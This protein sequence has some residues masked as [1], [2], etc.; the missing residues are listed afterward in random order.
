MTHRHYTHAKVMGERNSG[1][2]FVEALVAAN[3]RVEMLPN[4]MPFTARDEEMI[5]RIPITEAGREAIFHRAT[6]LNHFHEFARHAGW[7][8]ACLT[9]RHFK[10]VHN[11]HHTLFICVLRHPALWLKS[12]L[13][14]PF[15]TFYAENRAQSVRELFDTPW[16]TRPR[17]EITALVL[18]TPA[19]LW[20]HK[21]AS[22]LAARDQHP[23]VFVLRHEDLLRDHDP[24]L[25]D[26]SRPLKRATGD[27]IIPEGN[28]RSYMPRET[29][30]HRDFNA[31]RA[32]LP[33]DPWSVLDADLAGDLQN[34]IGVE[35]LERAGYP[36][37]PA[38]AA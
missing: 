29:E 2:N 14:A 32:E 12:M 36:P 4:T 19:L 10:L 22:Y 35:L 37:R 6:D 20:V 1:T 24:V 26:L 30:T 16:V 15:G 13:R 28:A 11:V 33:E 31:I 21:A 17:D 25:R 9:D 8:H 3:F 38:P 7:K 34:T 23:N 27:W 5:L 18:E